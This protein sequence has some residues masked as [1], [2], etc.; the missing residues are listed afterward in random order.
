VGT[1]RAWERVLG[2]RLAAR[3]PALVASVLQTLKDFSRVG[4]GPKFVVL[5]TDE[6]G[7]TRR[8]RYRWH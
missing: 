7:T 1:G 4:S 8:V 2:V 6:R 3:P 5:A